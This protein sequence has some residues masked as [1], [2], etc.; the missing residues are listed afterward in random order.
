MRLCHV[1]TYAPGFLGRF[2]RSSADLAGAPYAAQHERLMAQ[3]FGW[4]DFFVRY[5][6]ERGGEAVAIVANHAR[7]QR[8]WAKEHGLASDDRDTVLA[9]QIKTFAPDVLFLEDSF[10]IPASV[11]QAARRD[12]PGLRSVLGYVGVV[13]RMPPLARDLDLVVTSAPALDPPFAAAG[14][15][16]VTMYH[17]FEAGVLDEAPLRSERLGVTFVGSVAAGIHEDRRAVLEA[18][19]ER[20]PLVV[21]SDSLRPSAA[22]ALRSLAVATVRRRLPSYFK[23]MTSAM[24]RQAR[25][26]VYGLEMYSVL[27]ASDV[28][29]NFQGWGVSYLVPNMRLF[30]TTGM[31][32]CMVTDAKP[33]LEALFEPDREMVSYRSPGEC[34]EKVTWLLDHPAERAAIAMAGQR[35]TLKDHTLRS[36]VDGLLAQIESR[37]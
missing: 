19:A 3:R 36:R 23:L 35:R 13:N 6:H 22:T 25:P 34:A 26:A 31:G 37:L 14:V 7:A 20:A 30:E 2:Y 5:L 16:T 9:H 11:V 21:F 24:R 10:S 28:S 33:G 18:V 17:G 4:S 8:Q 15:R 29:I 32:A 1:T 27:Q 12:V